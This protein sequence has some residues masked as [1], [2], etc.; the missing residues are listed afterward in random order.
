MLKVL[1]KLFL[2][3]LVLAVGGAGFWYMLKTKPQ[4]QPI[5]AEEKTWLVSTVSV[6][7]QTLT[8]TVTLYGRVE[9]PR[10]AVLRAPTQTLSANTEVWA[11]SVLEGEHVNEN[12][13][14]IQLDDRDSQ[15]NLKQREAD[16][17]DLEAQIENEEKRHASNL[18]A[19]TYDEM[20]LKL[21]Q[22]SMNRAVQLK[23]QDVGSQAALEDTQKTVGQQMITVTNRRLE[24]ET[25]PARLAQLKAR[26]ERTVA[27]RDSAR[28]ELARAQVVAPFAGIV[29][30][31]SVSVGDRVR[32]GDALLALYDNTEL[33]VRAQIPN[34]YA[35]SVLETLA[36]E[37]VLIANAKVN[38]RPLFL[39]LDRV[40]GKISQDSGGIEGLFRVTK[41]AQFLRLGQFMT[42]V[43]NLPP[44]QQVVM[45]PFSA[46]Y[47][48]DRVYKSVA[49]R[50]QGLTIERVG[51]YAVPSGEIKILAYS[52]K[53]KAGD[54]IITTQLPNA[55]EGLKINVV[56]PK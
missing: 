36:T 10:D 48:T 5:K 34:R 41:G 2:A 8:P 27:L 25:H 49:G 43:L 44:Q 38:D 54:Q 9:S 7:P 31:V 23:K 37:Q 26:L 19:I 53:L 13:L 51:E 35:D 12:Q 28:L 4:A 21:T 11:V 22:E 17:L 1:Y 18:V 24:I 42:L 29:A 14:L 33:E 20:L 40:A 3:L 15:L 6:T 30:E 56:S 16:V 47:G 32:S 45:L 39:G 46:L 52:P 55:I 50:M